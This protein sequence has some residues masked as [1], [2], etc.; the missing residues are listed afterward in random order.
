MKVTGLP[1]PQVQPCENTDCLDLPLNRASIMPPHDLLRRNV[2]Q[3][4]VVSGKSL[5]RCA[6]KS[7]IVGVVAIP[8]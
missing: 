1:V 6:D 4:W 2:C 8:Q 3:Q 7:F 5:Q